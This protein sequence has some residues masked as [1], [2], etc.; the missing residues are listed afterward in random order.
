MW[1]NGEAAQ[2]NRPSKRLK[3]FLCNFPKTATLLHLMDY[4]LTRIRLHRYSEVKTP[5]RA[6]RVPLVFCSVFYSSHASNINDTKKKSKYGNGLPIPF[7]EIEVLNQIDK[8]RS[9]RV[10]TAHK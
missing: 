4:Q 2:R 3:R 6:A 9:I 5:K 1:H 10:I 7:T 8:K